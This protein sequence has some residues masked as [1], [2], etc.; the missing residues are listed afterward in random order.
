M[1]RVRRSGG[2]RRETDWTGNLKSWAADNAKA[3]YALISV[4][5][6]IAMKPMPAT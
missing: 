3:G 6:P 2:A 1:P 4:H 5:M